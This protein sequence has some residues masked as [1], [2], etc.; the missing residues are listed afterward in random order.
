MITQSLATKTLTS[1]AASITFTGIS[2]AYQDLTLLI[3]TVAVTSSQFIAIRF[4]GDS[5][6]KYINN[7]MYGGNVTQ[8]PVYASAGALRDY[9]SA[10]I[11]SGPT[12]TNLCNNSIMQI[13]SYQDTAKWKSVLVEAYDQAKDYYGISGGSYQSTNAITSI[14]VSFDNG[15]LGIG[16]QVTLLGVKA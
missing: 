12:N 2:T 6:N 13:Y 1:T 7:Y 8:T 3:R 11:T 14:A 10:G 5:T 15:L 4:N 9:L 16:T